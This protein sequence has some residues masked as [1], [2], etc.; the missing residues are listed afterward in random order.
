MS[1][2]IKSKLSRLFESTKPQQKQPQQN[3]VMRRKISLAMRPNLDLDATLTPIQSPVTEHKP[4]PVTTLSSLDNSSNNRPPSG[5]LF[6][7][8][9]DYDIGFQPKKRNSRY[10]K[11]IIR[12][13]H[14]FNSIHG[15]AMLLSL[16]Y[17]LSFPANPWLGCAHLFPLHTMPD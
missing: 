9:S 14:K 3:T 7:V 8:T 17:M 4:F 2:R 15:Y 6:S 12:T 1:K 11:R 13:L 5:D 16:L 10:E